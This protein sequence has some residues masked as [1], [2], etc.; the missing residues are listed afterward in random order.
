MLTCINPVF[1]T[2]PNRVP[3]N[4]QMGPKT[5][6]NFGSA[7]W[8]AIV[9]DSISRYSH[10]RVTRKCQPQAVRCQ[11]VCSTAV[12]TRFT[13]HDYIF[14]YTHIREPQTPAQ[15]C[16]LSGC[17][18]E[19]CFVKICRPRLCLNTAKSGNQEIPAKS[20]SHSGC[21]KLLATGKSRGVHCPLDGKL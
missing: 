8:E 12:S 18:V 7:F 13:N 6:R 21:L 16:L 5:G 14:K 20:R 10:I 15:R 4:E 11:A 2:M 1:R 17:P 19:G 3:L 9:T